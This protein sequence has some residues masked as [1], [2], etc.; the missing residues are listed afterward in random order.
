M[1]E[2][3]ERVRTAVVTGGGRGMGR[4]IAGRLADDGFSVAIGDIDGG[5]ASTAAS[6]LQSSGHAAE[7]FAVDVASAESVAGF[8]EAVVGRFGGVDALVNNAGVLSYR[9]LEL[10]DESE[11]D[12]NID[13][14]LKGPYLCTRAALNHLRANGWGRVVNISSEVGKIGAAELSHYSASKFGVIG[15]T[16]SLA[17]ELAKTG[18]T[19]N[20]ICPAITNT[21]MMRL[22]AREQV[23]LHGEGDEDEIMRQSA[24]SIP[25]GRATEPSDVANA[26]SFL[27]SDGAEFITGQSINVTGGNLMH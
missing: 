26:V 21:S 18:V 25:I 7:G 3:T 23:Q 22:I 2:A 14:N 24:A 13:I 1:T 19:V 9:S 4:A 15:L 16:Q 6:E 20:A 5:A 11:W 12:R 10:L 27:C 8:F 17:L